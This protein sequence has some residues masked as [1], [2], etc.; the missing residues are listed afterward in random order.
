MSKEIEVKFINIDKELILQKLESIGAKKVHDEIL[1]RRCVYD[2]PHAKKGSWSRIRD[3]GIKVTMTYKCIN[4]LSID[5]V[6]EVEIE[7]D[8]FDRGREFLRAIGLEEK[9]YQETKRIRYILEEEG[10]E[11]DIDTW[12][13][14]EPWLEIEGKNKE[15]VMKY[16]KMLG[17]EWSEGLFGSADYIY[18]KV[19]KISN[20]WINNNC[21]TLK[22][23]SIPP[24]LQPNNMR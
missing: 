9:A 23:D 2:L 18:S 12:P 20:E 21:P 17:F 4:S 16:S 6:E 22:F 24:K 19:Y 15:T 8:D 11:F 7:I 5:G 10:V 3:E 1:L 13:A 14:L